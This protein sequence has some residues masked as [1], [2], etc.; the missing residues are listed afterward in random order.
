MRHTRDED[1][2]E[3]VRR[4]LPDLGEIQLRDLAGVIERLVTAMQPDLIYLFGSYARGTAGFDSD[5]DLLVVVPESDLPPHRRDQLAYRAVGGHILPIDILVV[6]RREFE[7]QR[8][9][10]SSLPATVLREGRVLYAA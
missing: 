4:A 10:V 6:T 8:Q 9:S 2:E 7:R 5:V 1:L 3:Q